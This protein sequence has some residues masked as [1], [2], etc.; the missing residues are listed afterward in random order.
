VRKHSDAANARL[1]TLLEEE[2]LAWEQIHKLTQEQAQ[3]LDS[4]ELDSLEKSID[5]RQHLME[6]INGLHQESNDLMQ[7]YN[8][9]QSGSKNTAI[10]AVL[11]KLRKMIVLCS[12]QNE[13]NIISA[14]E[15]KSGFIARVEELGQKR[16]SIGAY[17]PDITESSELFDKKM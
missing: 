1:L 7:S 10:E 13:T 17:A 14:E 11:G 16:K 5:Q 9:H 2:L 4:E 12:E 15:I 3:L 8:K 6:K